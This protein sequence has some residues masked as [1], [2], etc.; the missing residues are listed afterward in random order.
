[1]KDLFLDIHGKD[2][3]FKFA[4]GG[5]NVSIPFSLENPRADLI[6]N[7]TNKILMTFKDMSDFGRLC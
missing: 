7:E 5:K 2:T 4:M 3:S 6:Y 1:M